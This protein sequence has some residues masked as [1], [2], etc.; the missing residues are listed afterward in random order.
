MLTTM[1]F[2]HDQIATMLEAYTAQAREAFMATTSCSPDPSVAMSDAERRK[3]RSARKA[4]EGLVKRR[5]GETA[6]RDYRR[7]QT[8]LGAP[9]FSQ[10]EKGEERQRRSKSGAVRV[11]IVQR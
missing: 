3:L 6:W 11:D 9:T 7:W 2:D 8:E 1:S 5:I 4:A 10:G